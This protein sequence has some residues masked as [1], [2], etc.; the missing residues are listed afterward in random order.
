MVVVADTPESWGDRENGICGDGEIIGCIGRLAGAVFESSAVGAEDVVVTGE[1]GKTLALG[2][3]TGSGV[4]SV[5][6]AGNALTWFRDSGEDGVAA[7]G[8]NC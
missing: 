7:G 8:E 5:G 2:R 1:A 6:R 4:G 3:E